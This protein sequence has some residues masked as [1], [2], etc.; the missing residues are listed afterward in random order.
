MCVHVCVR[1]LYNLSR[2]GG[3]R[4]T[5]NQATVHIPSQQVQCMCCM[6]NHVH[7]ILAKDIWKVKA[8][9]PTNLLHTETKASTYVYKTKE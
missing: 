1:E 4:E 3:D 7:D 8:K 6:E 5:E 2:Y 9:S